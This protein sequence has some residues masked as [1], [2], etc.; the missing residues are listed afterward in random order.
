MVQANSA[1]TEEEMFLCFWLQSKARTR[2]RE[3][4]FFFNQSVKLS[5]SVKAKAEN[6]P[7]MKDRKSLCYKL[8]ISEGW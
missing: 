3:F 2:E 7:E 1:D 4:Y 8:N 6:I 5:T